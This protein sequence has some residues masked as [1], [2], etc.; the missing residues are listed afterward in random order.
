MYTNCRL[1]ALATILAAPGI[2]SAGPMSTWGFVVRDPQ[3]DQVLASATG[4]TVSDYVIPAVLAKPDHPPLPSLT[5]PAEWL[6]KYGPGAPYASSEPWYMVRDRNR[7]SIV[8]TDETRELSSP[9]L[10]VYRHITQVYRYDPDTG[11]WPHLVEWDDSYGTLDWFA[12]HEGDPDSTL[13]RIKSNT[14]DVTIQAKDWGVPPV[15]EPGTLLLG[16]FGLGSLGFVRLA[17]RRLMPL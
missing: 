16:G 5:P 10:E 11:A 4:L 2:V 6:E 13:F 7:I 14:G 3:T 12:W 17:R 8:V 9:D 1:W 15:P